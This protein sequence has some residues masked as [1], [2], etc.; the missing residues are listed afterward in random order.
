[1][2]KI[3]TIILLQVLSVPVFSQQIDHAPILTRQDYLKKSDNQKKAA[4]ILLV[5]GMVVSVVGLAIALDNVGNILNPDQPDNGKI[6]DVLGYSGLVIAAA[7][8]P[9]F[10]ASSKNEKKAVSMS[11]KNQLVP[12]FQGVGFVHRV[13]PS[14]HLKISI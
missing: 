4:K 8:I 6:A 9:L 7:S 10:V 3:T 2:K 1:M 12:Q 14:L 13:V 5:G 11:F